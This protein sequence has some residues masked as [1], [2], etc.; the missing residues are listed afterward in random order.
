M[1][2]DL[3]L[4][5]PKYDARLVKYEVLEALPNPV[6]LGRVHKP[7]PH[8]RLVDA[9]RREI[10]NRGHQITREQFALSRSGAA[11]FGMMNLS[12]SS[13]NSRSWA[14]GFRNATDQTFGITGVAGASVF[15]CDNMALRG[16]TFAVQ[17]KNTT[18][19]DLG[20]AIA[21]G[22]DKFLTQVREF[23]VEIL[24]L[25]AAELSNNVA[26]RIIYD[27]FAGGIAP[28]RLFDDVD[29]FY[30]RPTTEQPE[31]RERTLWGLH[32]AFT[33]AFR[34]LTPVRRMS[35]SVA[36]GAHFTK[37]LAGREVVRG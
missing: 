8:A 34:D 32:N 33:R 12:G 28:S 13:D 11:L 6:P 14:F 17:R 27:A 16:S 10:A 5:N 9:L 2:T 35:A 3:I 20:D 21:S 31:C 4:H 7:V 36:L 18:R 25:A 23:E 1:A 24:A 29:Q 30:F 15:V 26:K 19:L 37:A 22:F